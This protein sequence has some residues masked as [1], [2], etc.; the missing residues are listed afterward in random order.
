MLS[1][2]L[3]RRAALGGAALIAALPAWAAVPDSVVLLAP[4]PE[5]GAAA[6]LALRASAGLSRGLIQAAALR[7]AVL[8][9]PDGI[10]AANR[11]ASA[12]APDGRS[13]LLLP[14]A[15]AQAHLVG[16]SRARFEPRQ[17]TPVAAVMRPVLVA[18]RGD[19]PGLARAPLRLA[20]PSPD[21]PGDG[22]AAGARPARAR[23]HA[24][25]RPARGGRGGRRRAGRR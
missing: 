5:E 2:Q 13:L 17:W 18:G 25:L 24:R 22:G 16:E 20:L 12:A 4:G 15:A 23:G 9:G 6:R 10:T 8:G 3:T 1:T 14:G 11:F 7:V 21:A 19:L